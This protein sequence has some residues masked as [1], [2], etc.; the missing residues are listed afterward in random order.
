MKPVV[1]VTPLRGV[2]RLVVVETRT[3]GDV[4][5]TR[6]KGILAADVERVAG[7]RGRRDE[8][9]PGVGVDDPDVLA[10]HAVGVEAHA[11]ERDVV[12]DGAAGGGVPEAGGTCMC[13]EYQNKLAIQIQ[14]CS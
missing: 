1:L 5:T 10:T 7:L 11:L 8:G 4:V 14:V 3:T 12:G 9:L 2:Y 13:T 6:A